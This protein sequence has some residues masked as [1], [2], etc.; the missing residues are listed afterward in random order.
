ME[1]SAARL[2]SNQQIILGKATFQEA[3]VK[4]FTFSEISQISIYMTSN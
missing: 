1:A 3:F 2:L 4:L